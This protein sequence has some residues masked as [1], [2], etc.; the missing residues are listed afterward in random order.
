MKNAWLNIMIILL[1]GAAFVI[2]FP[3]PAAWIGDATV[4]WFVVVGDMFVSI[5]NWMTGW[6]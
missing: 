1:V 4:S 5:W 2:L 6:L 3:A